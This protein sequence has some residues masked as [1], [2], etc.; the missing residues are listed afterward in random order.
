M[1]LRDEIKKEAKTESEYNQEQQAIK[2][3]KRKEADERNGQALIDKLKFLLK[4]AAS[5][6]R[7]SRGQISGTLRFESEIVDDNGAVDGWRYIG[8]NLPPH[9][10]TR[11]T[12]RGLGINRSI[13]NE[14][15]TKTTV[16]P[17]EDIW[18]AY[19]IL[20][21]YAINE[22]ITLSDL[23]I[24]DSDG[25]KY[26]KITATVKEGIIAVKQF[27]YAVDFYMNI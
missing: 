7:I 13:Y 24:I 3:K 6:G 17:T 26:R 8:T 4:D 5:K 2:D 9:K 21:E 15:G 16:T 10:E 20:K 12:Y 27:I 23:Y 18:G 14:K 11:T 1:S 25:C 22:N 19:S